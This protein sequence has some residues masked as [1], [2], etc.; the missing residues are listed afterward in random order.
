MRIDDL[1]CRAARTN[2]IVLNR[3][4]SDLVGSRGIHIDPS[5]RPSDDGSTTRNKMIVNE[6]AR[7]CGPSVQ[8]LKSCQIASNYEPV[9]AYARGKSF[10]FI[11]LPPLSE[12][13]Q[14]K[15]S[16][17]ISYHPVNHLILSRSLVLSCSLPPVS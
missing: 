9:D 15:F 16:T 6:N 10:R 7:T 17:P 13:R 5:I 3:F 8:R 12:K 14:Q 11:R 1:R 4:S 2:I